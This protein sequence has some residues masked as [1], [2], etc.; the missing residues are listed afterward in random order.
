MQ[1]ITVSFLRKRYGLNSNKEV[2]NFLK[3]HL[4]QINFDAPHIQISKGEW[5]FDSEALPVIDAAFG[6]VELAESGSEDMEVN[7]QLQ[8]VQHEL[9]IARQQIDTLKDELQ[10]ANDII[11]NDKIEHQKLQDEVVTV[12]QQQDALNNSL[13]QRNQIRAEKAEKEVERLTNRLASTIESKDKQIAELKERVAEHQQKLTDQIKLMEEKAKAEF[14]V[15]TAKKEVDRVYSK[16]HESEQYT[17]KLNQQLTD[18]IE[19]KEDALNKVSTIQHEI[20]RALRQLSNIQEQLSACVEIKAEPIEMEEEAIV[21]KSTIIDNSAKAASQL[22]NPPIKPTREQSEIIEKLHR[23]Q[24]A[25]QK[26]AKDD[27]SWWN[28]VASFFA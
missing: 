7:N 18:S 10:K 2:G 28:R 1:K 27:N 6:Y 24:E 25:K 19:A 9:E 11:R 20:V 13:I 8:V 15:L 26:A 23:E 21:T 3:E 14:D 4:E 17:D 5:H 16:I 12:R 22:A